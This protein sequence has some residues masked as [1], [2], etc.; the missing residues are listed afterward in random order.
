MDV[1]WA[2]LTVSGVLFNIEATVWNVVPSSFSF[3]SEHD[4]GTIGALEPSPE[5]VLKSPGVEIIR[6]FVE[7][8]VEWALKLLGESVNI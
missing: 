8:M 7:P 2:E 3:I 1:L 6:T 5:S 4:M